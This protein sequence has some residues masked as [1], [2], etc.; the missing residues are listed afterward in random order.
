MMVSLS[1]IKKAEY[2][3]CDLRMLRAKAVEGLILLAVQPGVWF[4]LVKTSL[5]NKES[6]ASRGERPATIP[7]IFVAVIGV[8]SAGNTSEG[9]HA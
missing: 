9:V 1:Q 7:A 5:L 2:R 4:T 8:C 3:K 6:L